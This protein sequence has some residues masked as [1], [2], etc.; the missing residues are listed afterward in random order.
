MAAFLIFWCVIGAV[1][2]LMIG[3]SKGRAGEGFVLGL[4]LGVIGWVIIAVM[5][6]STEVRAQRNAEL[7]AMVHPKEGPMTTDARRACPWCAELILPEAKVCRFCGRDVEP[8]AVDLDA[9]FAEV[10]ARH[11]GS[12]DQAFAVLAV[13]DPAP[14]RPADWLEQLCSR[15]DAGS[16]AEA[17]AS[18]IP[19]DYRA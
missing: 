5:E 3:S 2:G 19:L 14:D 17:A 16:P 1:V 6:P 9:S 18:R 10:R 11:P 13:A 8:V 4:L 12:F 7:A 15:I